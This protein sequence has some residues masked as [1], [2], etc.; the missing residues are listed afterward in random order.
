MQL[1]H[2]LKSKLFL[3]QLIF[4]VIGLGIFIFAVMKWM[5]ITTNHDQKI[6]V[7][8]L[9]E[10]TMDNVEKTLTEIDLK[11]VVLD[12]MSYNP[13]YPKKSVI[14]QDPKAGNFVKENRKI[15]LTMNPSGYKNVVIPDLY[16]RTKRQAV[17][18]LRAVGFRVSDEFEYVSD[19]GLDVVRAL[20]F[21][22]K[23]VKSGQKI[24]KNSLL[25][26]KLGDGQGSKRYTP[27]NGN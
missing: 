24:P 7:P 5:N 10:M 17:S 22:G 9:Q 14:E 11:W 3:K 21:N 8:E 23:E 6:E 16:G 20:M 26:L 18:Q 15:Y 4:A 27:K 25:M 13:N 12:S 2:F 1:L 19:I